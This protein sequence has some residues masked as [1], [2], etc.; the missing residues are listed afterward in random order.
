VVD[1][2]FEVPPSQ[3]HDASKVLPRRGRT[4][5]GRRGCG[6]HQ[7]AINHAIGSA[8]AV[9]D[10]TRDMTIFRT[11]SCFFQSSL[12]ESSWRKPSCS[13]GRDRNSVRG[14]VLWQGL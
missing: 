3:L 5:D 4:R 14:G 6:G 11:L 13:P 10:E 7:R 8:D 12:A 9:A 1:G 2:G